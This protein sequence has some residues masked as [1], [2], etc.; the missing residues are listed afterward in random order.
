M[1]PTLNDRSAAEHDWLPQLYIRIL[2]GTML[3][4]RNIGSSSNLGGSH[5]SYH[6]ACRSGRNIVPARSCE[7][8]W[9]E[10]FEEPPQLCRRFRVDMVDSASL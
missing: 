5:E 8:E 10:T 9:Q 6:H 3:V 2:N 1:S 7:V 4:L